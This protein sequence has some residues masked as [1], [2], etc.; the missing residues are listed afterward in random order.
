MTK[1]E[2]SGFPVRVSFVS[3]KDFGDRS[4]LET[5]DWVEASDISGMRKMKS[6]ISQLRA[7]G[8]G[9]TPEDVAGGFEEALKLFDSCENSLKVVL[10]VADAPAHGFCE[11]DDKHLVHNG[12]N[13]SK[14][15]M[16]VAH[17]LFVQKGAELLFCD[18]GYGRC[19]DKMVDALDKVLKEHGTFVDRFDI[20]G[21]SDKVFLEK[22]VAQ[23]EGL[24]A[25]SVG[26]PAT[27]GIDLFHGADLSVILSIICSRFE[28]KVRPLVSEDE[29]KEPSAIERLVNKLED[30]AY[31]MVRAVMSSVE[32]GKYAT[33]S[34]SGG[35]SDASVDSLF[36]AGVSVKQLKEAGYPLSIIEKYEQ[37]LK[38]QVG[39][40]REK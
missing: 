17:D 21:S 13:Q 2:S 36:R 6:F 12:I 4:H 33:Y 1:I 34:F 20:P 19:N 32:S 8:G 40:V 26:T 10:L 39:I 5:H 35:L 7:S 24:I 23:M 27:E 18:V 11:N 38:R 30:C 31:D 15:L 9:D 28:D 25:Y 37:R 22:V 3:Y 14:R 16:K 29:M